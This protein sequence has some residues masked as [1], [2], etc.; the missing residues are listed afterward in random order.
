MSDYEMDFDIEESPKHQMLDDSCSGSFQ[1][2][3][4]EGEESKHPTKRKI[5]KSPTGSFHEELIDEDIEE[6]AKL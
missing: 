1:S 3:E 5:S 4:L 6:E 2:I